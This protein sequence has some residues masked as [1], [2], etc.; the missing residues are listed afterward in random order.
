M[1]KEEIAILVENV[2][3]EFCMESAVIHAL[4]DISININCGEFISIVGPSGCGKTTLLRLI[5]NLQEPTSGKLLVNGKTPHQARLDHDFSIVFQDHALLEWRTALQNILL[6]L[7]LLNRT[8]KDS[9]D[10]CR[11]LL[12]LVGLSKF[13]DCYPN[14]LS[15][16]MKQRVSIAR[17]L[18]LDPSLL[19]MD[20]P[21]GSLDQITRDK[22]NIELLNLI[23]REKKMTT[24]FVTHSIRE[25][26]FLADRVVVLSPHPGRLIDIVNVNLDR[27]RDLGIRETPRFR[28]IY[29][30]VE[31][32][33]DAS[34]E[35]YLMSHP[36]EE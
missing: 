28:E 24:I 30:E 7:E 29:F 26:I 13:A 25:A 31:E 23:P 8:R 34:Q 9:L 35:A 5:G 36:A 14:E 16:G 32:K 19:L 10:K 12:D 18:V 2:N 1:G 15:G 21:F 11:R 33:L 20:E 4:S 27:P 6:P 17:A 22:M 3:V